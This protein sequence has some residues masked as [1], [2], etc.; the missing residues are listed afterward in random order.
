[1]SF[2][3]IRAAVGWPCEDAT[4]ES[5]LLIRDSVTVDGNDVVFRSNLW[6]F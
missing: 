2:D 4:R 5:F 3:D 6:M 1:M